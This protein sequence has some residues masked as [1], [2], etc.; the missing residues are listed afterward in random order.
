MLCIA[1]CCQSASQTVM[2]SVPYS[3]ARVSSEDENKSSHYNALRYECFATAHANKRNENGIS[4]R[5]Q[6]DSEP[7][8]I[9]C[10]PP[11]KEKPPR[12]PK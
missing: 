7:K 12:N 8:H 9:S 4:L 11:H 5:C 1:Q 10:H 3:V 6:S 2:A